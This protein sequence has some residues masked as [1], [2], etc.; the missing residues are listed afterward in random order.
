MGGAGTYPLTIVGED[1]TLVKF[2]ASELVLECEPPPCCDTLDV[3]V[4][5]L[6]DPPA[7]CYNSSPATANVTITFSACSI[8]WRIYQAN[9]EGGED[10]Y[11]S[12]SGVAPVVNFSYTLGSGE[13]WNDG[14]LCPMTLTRFMIKWWC[15]GLDPD[16]DTESGL[17]A[18]F[19]VTCG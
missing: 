12:G 10:L 16:I 11:S 3:T 6:T 17:I 15:D 8:Q 4:E 18:V 2:G 13:Q 19:S 7:E 1:G 14:A 5:D 9:C